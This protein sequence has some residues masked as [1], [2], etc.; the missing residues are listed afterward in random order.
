MNKERKKRKK[1]GKKEKWI[2]DHDLLFFLVEFDLH[3]EKN[4]DVCCSGV[5][6]TK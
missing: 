6:N 4:R 1:E 2:M 5:C 3:Y